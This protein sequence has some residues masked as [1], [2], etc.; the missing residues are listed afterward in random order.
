[1]QNVGCFEKVPFSGEVGPKFSSLVFFSASTGLIPK[2]N[3]LIPPQ[4]MTVIF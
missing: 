4:Q 2:P 1:M 3:G